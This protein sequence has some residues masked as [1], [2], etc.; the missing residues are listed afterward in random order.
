MKAG[1]VDTLRAS[2]VAARLFVNDID[3]EMS[4]SSASSDDVFAPSLHIED[5]E[6]DVESSADVD[7]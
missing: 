7:K 3:V 2:V 6:S 1:A 5:E 4:S